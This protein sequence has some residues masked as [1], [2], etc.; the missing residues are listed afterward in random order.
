MSSKL[1]VR[2]LLLKMMLRIPDLVGDFDLC[3]LNLTK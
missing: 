2:T 1:T 3:V